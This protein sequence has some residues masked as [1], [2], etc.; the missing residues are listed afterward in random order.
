MSIFQGANVFPCV[1][2]SFVSPV[3]QVLPSADISQVFL[4]LVLFILNHICSYF[5]RHE[6]QLNTEK[7]KRS[8]ARVTSNFGLTLC[9]KLIIV[10]IVYSQCQWQAIPKVLVVKGRSVQDFM[11][12]KWSALVIRVTWDV[13]WD[14]DKLWGWDGFPKT[15]ER[16]EEHVSNCFWRGSKVP[17]PYVLLFCNSEFLQSTA[18]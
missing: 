7:Y 2:Q 1:F 6:T 16:R 4:K 3:F 15:R 10:C 17:V 9:D 12:L 14:F 18:L 5:Q 13:T 11:Y 8:L